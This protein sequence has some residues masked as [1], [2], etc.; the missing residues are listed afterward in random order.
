MKDNNIDNRLKTNIGS[1]S[2]K[3]P[4][5][6][7]SGTFGY[8]IEYNDFYDVSSL[9][10]IIVKGTTGQKREGNPYPRLA[11]TPQ[12]MI[13]A[14]GLQN[15]G[16]DYFCDNIYPKIKDIND[17]IIVNVSGSSIEEYVLVAQKIN[18]LDNITAIELNISCPN[19]KKGGMGFGTNPTMAAEVTKEVR[20]VY[21]KHLIVKLTPNVTSVVD[22][23]KSVEDAG[24]DSLSLINTVLA[25]AVDSEKQKPILSTITGGLSGAAIKPIALRCVWQVA[26]N[27]KVPVIGIGGI[28]SASDVV[29]FMLVGASAVEIGTMN[30]IN[31][32]IGQEIINDLSNY[33]DRHNISNI[34][35]IVGKI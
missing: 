25:M 4:I 24:A 33:L 15:K 23:A 16:V 6:T 9:G 5:L 28:C 31:P 8:G 32:R 29:E 7:A 12:G 35:D 13:N 27:V 2:L 11:E 20:K 19:V 22:I 14:V 26:H 18:E 3:N 17:N 21:K 10:G 1:L 34:K 30:F